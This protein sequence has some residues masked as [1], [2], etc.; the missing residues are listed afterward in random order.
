MSKK[1]VEEVLAKCPPTRDKES[2]AYSKGWKDACEA[3][4][5]KCTEV[6]QLPKVVPEPI[7]YLD[8]E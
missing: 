7:T 2:S 6:A 3:I 5:A 1:V 8:E 4:L